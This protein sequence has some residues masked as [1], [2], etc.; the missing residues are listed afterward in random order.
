MMLLFAN[1]SFAQQWTIQEFSAA[2]TAKDIK[3]L[4]SEEKEVIRYVNLA[5]MF[6]KKFASIEIKKAIDEELYKESDYTKSLIVL[7][8]KMSPVAAISFDESMYQ[9]AKCFA[10]ESGKL[11]SYGHKRIHC[12]NGFDAECCSYGCQSGLLVVLQLLIDQGVPSLGHRS[13]CLNRTMEKVGVSIQPHTQYNYCC[14]L[15]FKLKNEE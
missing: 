1:L 6:P 14:V 13:I 2:N 15:D 11:G 9:I 8:N 7:L 12:V 10:I 3:V 4:N 5:R